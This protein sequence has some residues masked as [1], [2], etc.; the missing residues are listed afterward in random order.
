V[1][2]KLS[3]KVGSENLQGDIAF[4]MAPWKKN[5]TNYRSRKKYSYRGAFVHSLTNTAF[6]WSIVLMLLMLLFRKRICTEGGRMFAFKYVFG[7]I[8]AISALIVWGTYTNLPKVNA[9]VKIRINAVHKNTEMLAQITML[10]MKNSA[11]MTLDQIRAELEKWIESDPHWNRHRFGWGKIKEHDSPGN[12]ILLEDGRGIVMRLFYYGGFWK[13][14]LIRE[15]KA[16]T[17]SPQP[18]RIFP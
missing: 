18:Y 8:T 6:Y 16:D 17:E 3:G 7:T 1:L 12:Y 5:N 10:E 11:T 15:S 4:T 14:I 2:T 13:D 9:K